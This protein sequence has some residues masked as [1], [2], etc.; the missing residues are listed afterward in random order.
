MAR[1]VRVT[2][3]DEPVDECVQK[4]LNII[5]SPL[6]DLGNDAVFYNAKKAAQTQLRGTNC[7]PAVM[8]RLDDLHRELTDSV[9]VAA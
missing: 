6:E 8:R 3:T 9:L 1:F 7:W 4:V 5:K 2:L